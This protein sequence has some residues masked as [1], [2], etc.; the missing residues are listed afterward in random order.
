M[1]RDVMCHQPEQAALRLDLRRDVMRWVRHLWVHYGTPGSDVLRRIHVGM[2]RVRAALA[3]K[4]VL[5]QTIGFLAVTALMTRPRRV[6][7]INYD[8]GQPPELRLV[9]DK[10]LHLSKGPTA[11]SGALVLP[12]PCP[13]SDVP[14]V[15]DG[16]P[17][18]CVFGKLND[19]FADAVV[20]VTT[21]AR[22]LVPKALQRTTYATRALAAL[23]LAA[24]LALQPLSAQGTAAADGVHLSPA[25]H[26]AVARGGKVHHAEIDTQEVLNF[27]RHA[28]GHVNCR[29]EIKSAITIDEIDLSLD[30]VEAFALVLAVDHGHDH[31]ART[32]QNA[33]RSR[34]LKTETPFVIGDRAIGTKYRRA[35]LVAPEHLNRFA[36]RAHGQLRGQPILLAQLVVAESVDRGLTEQARLE[37]CA[38]RMCRSRVARR[39]HVAERSDLLQLRQQLDL[40]GEFHGR[41]ITTERLYPQPPA[42]HL[43]AKAGG[44]SRS[45]LWHS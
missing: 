17:A 25:E 28:L 12:E 5:L 39:H 4:A 45:F 36:D 7:G 11:H 6:G 10:S 19:L 24:G 13:R 43:P 30:T 32:G 2:G 42:I 41:E 34:T 23:L 21:E 9:G 38:R 16:N 26:L 35:G 14:Q 37:S 22:L 3:D 15:F 27:Y 18:L 29:V 8:K 1:L 31:T 33:A 20:L 44:F 40:Q